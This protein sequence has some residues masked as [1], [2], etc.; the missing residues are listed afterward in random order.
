MPHLDAIE[1]RAAGLAAR[2]RD[3]AYVE[4]FREH[5]SPPRRPRVHD[6]ERYAADWAPLVPDNAE[7]RAELAHALGGRHRLPRDRVPAIRAAL[8][9]DDAAVRAAYQRR[10]G[11]SLD[12]LFTTRLGLGERARWLVH[13]LAGS[14]DRLPPFWLT[15]VL[16]VAV[17][18]P[19]SLLGLPIAASAMGALPALALLGVVGL[20]MSIA[21]GGL[22]EAIA[23]SGEVR[24]RH[25][26]LGG[27]ATQLIGARGSIVLTGTGGVRSAMALLAGWIGLSIGAAEVTHTPR[28]IWAGLIL[29][30]V[31]VMLTRG[32]KLALGTVAL[33]GVV[34]TALVLAATALA[35]LH[36]GPGN[37]AHADVPIGGGNAALDQTVGA[38]LGVVLMQ[39][40]GSVYLIGIRREVGA[41][42]PDASTLAAGAFVG[43]VVV[44]VIVGLWLVAVSAAVPA[45]DLRATSGTAIGPLA[46]EIGPAMAVIGGIAALL[47]LG[48]NI[49][50]A[51]V[52]VHQLTLE[53]LSRVAPRLQPLLGLVP[54][55]LLFGIAETLLDVGDASFSSILTI[56]G[57]VTNVLVGAAI[58]MLLLLAARRRGELVPERVWQWLGWPPL[59]WAIVAA[60]IAALVVVGLFVWDDWGS[61]SAA[62]A[63]AVVGAA[64]VWW[65]ARA[66]AFRPRCVVELVDGRWAVV[67]GGRTL[68]VDAELSYDGRDP[69][70][71]HAS[72][73]ALGPGLS[74]LRV[75]GDA[76]NGAEEVAVWRAGV[77]VAGTDVSQPDIDGAWSASVEVGPRGGNR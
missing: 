5:R 26:F 64:T 48:M 38:A 67:A 32:A 16:T 14:L 41:R 51:A 65:A 23:R 17:T 44:T 8:R 33:F 58:P 57:V 25:A 75:H 13:A 27:L 36:A 40:I 2:T 42:D 63:M 66:H 59:A 22:G 60:A 18:L 35:F 72:G 10:Y 61:R 56:S 50:R 68:A 34:A 21:M 20:V 24:Y 54:V 12:E 62:L 6:L 28:G 4:A 37:L 74:G 43:T 15:V 45:A 9:L 46:D 76:A 19:V 53:R 29:A 39:Y 30:A 49:N 3:R 11:A 73:G 71:V 55:L 7:A 47:L 70:R 69:T 31:I 52:A 77:E 1:H